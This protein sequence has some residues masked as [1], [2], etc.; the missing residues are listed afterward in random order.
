MG[1]LTENS[2]KKFTQKTPALNEAM[3]DAKESPAIM[4]TLITFN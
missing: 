2:R 4:L 3:I 1:L